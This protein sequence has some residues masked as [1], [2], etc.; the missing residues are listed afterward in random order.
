[1]DLL[2][3]LNRELGQTLVMVTHDPAT[4]ARAARTVRLDKGQIIDAPVQEHAA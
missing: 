4:A 2:A 1:M 3:R